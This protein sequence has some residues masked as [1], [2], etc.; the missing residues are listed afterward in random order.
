MLQTSR[1]EAPNKDFFDTDD[2]VRI[3]TGLPSMEILMVSSTSPDMLHGKHS[4]STESTHFKSSLLYL[5]NLNWM[6]RCKI[7]YTSLLF[8]CQQFPEY[9]PTRLLRWTPFCN[10]PNVHKRIVH[11][12]R[13]S[14]VG[15]N[16]FVCDFF[17]LN[18]RNETRNHLVVGVQTFQGT[19]LLICVIACL[20]N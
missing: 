18:W 12:L 8:Y 13:I 9:F 3:Y 19:K 1:Y 7:L 15:H 6:H 4:R 10:D 5:W 16:N 20:Q 11:L 17:P 2:I 14:Q